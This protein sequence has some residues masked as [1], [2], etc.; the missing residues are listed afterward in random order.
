MTTYDEIFTEFISITKTDPFNI[1]T[2]TPKIHDLIHSAI[3]HY[4]NRMRDTLSYNDTA[5][6]VDRILNDDE[7]IIIAHYLR[8][9]FLENQL[10]NFTTIWQPFEKDIG[11]KNY[12][13]QAKSLE[14]LIDNEKIEIESLI[15]NTQTD[16][17]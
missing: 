15:N 12:G 17:M 4:N 11:L 7:L 5:E 8:F 9:S 13:S 10:I 6:T 3:R 16:F 1:P 14:V 2:L